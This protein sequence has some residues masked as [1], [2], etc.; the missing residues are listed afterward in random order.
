MLAIALIGLSL[1]M[2]EYKR[3]S[4]DQKVVTE[5]VSSVEDGEIDDDEI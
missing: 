2:M 3:S 4:V 5:S 1:A